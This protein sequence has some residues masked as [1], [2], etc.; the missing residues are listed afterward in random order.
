MKQELAPYDAFGRQALT[1]LAAYTYLLE[2]EVIVLR[3]Q[4]AD[5]ENTDSH[6]AD[7]DERTGLAE[8]YA[9]LNKKVGRSYGDDPTMYFLSRLFVSLVSSFEYFLQDTA[10]VVVSKN[11]KKVGGANF[12][13]SEVLDAPTPDALVRRAIDEWL[14][15]LMYK[16]PAEY[17]KE[18]T[19]VLSIDEEKLRV[20]WS[21]FVEAKARR[22]L[23]VHNEWTCN[24]IYLRKI[25]EAG[26]TT[27][28]T[29]GARMVPDAAYVKRIN[30]ALLNLATSLSTLVLEKHWPDSSL[31]ELNFD[32]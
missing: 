7:D 14:N 25:A 2:A 20:G 1:L 19:T 13:L 4:R 29:V 5:K 3:K 11:P 9:D 26:L 22:D 12:T 6:Q 17:L 27:D 30:T 28:A 24:A 18:L 31:E 16:K 10:V 21:T 8:A 23:G 15:K 32:W